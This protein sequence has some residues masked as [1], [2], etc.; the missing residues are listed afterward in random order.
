MSK[1]SNHMENIGSMVFAVGVLKKSRGFNKVKLER[2]NIAVIAMFITLTCMLLFALAICWRQSN[3]YHMQSGRA[4][5]FEN[6]VKLLQ[7]DDIQDL[8][9]HVRQV[10]AGDIVYELG[11]ESV[12]TSPLAVYSFNAMRRE[13]FPTT[14]RIEHG[15]TVLEISIDG[16]KGEVVL[17]YFI[18]YVDSTGRV[19][20]GRADGPLSPSR[21][22]IERHGGRWAI[23]E[24]HEFAQWKTRSTE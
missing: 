18:R 1:M 4:A 7:R 5:I 3:M 12:N 2:K 21:W 10:M 24:I 11:G 13:M 22:T 19:V 17:S 20:H 15:L 23:T 14:E 6:T 16:D 9:F 8:L